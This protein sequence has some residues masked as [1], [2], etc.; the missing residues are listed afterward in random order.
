M[1]RAEFHRISHELRSAHRAGKQ[2]AHLFN[3]N[4]T[5][6]AILARSPVMGIECKPR[7]IRDRPIAGRV[8]EEL[9]WA[10]SYL[11]DPRR[12]YSPTARIAARDCLT[13]ARALLAQRSVFDRQP[14]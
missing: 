12:R 2:A 3:H 4:G 5:Y 1:N 11:R 14:A 6:W 7:I 13:D 8:A 9:A 10:W